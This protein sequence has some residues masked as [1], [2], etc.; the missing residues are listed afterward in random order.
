MIE[1]T[2]K[3]FKELKAKG[4]IDKKL[5]QINT[6]EAKYSPCTETKAMRKWCTDYDYRRREWQFRNSVANYALHN[7]HKAFGKNIKPII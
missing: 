3:K 2:D 5:K 6:F 1:F 4:L 7:G